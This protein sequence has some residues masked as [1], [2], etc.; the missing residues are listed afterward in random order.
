M[1]IILLKPYLNQ[2]M[3]DWGKYFKSETELHR[4]KQNE[5]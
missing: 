5:R 3:L 4:H 2:I 1:L